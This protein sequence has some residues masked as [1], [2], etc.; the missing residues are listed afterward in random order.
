MECDPL[1]LAELKHLVTK[2]HSWRLNNLRTN[3]ARTPEDVVVDGTW[4]KLRQGVYSNGVREGMSPADDRMLA[5]V[6]EMLP[7]RHCERPAAQPQCGVRKAQG[8]A[9]QCRRKPHSVLWTLLWWST[10]V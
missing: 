4:R 3:L 2:K 6:R 9:K 1:L 8:R 7:Q 10:S 5:I